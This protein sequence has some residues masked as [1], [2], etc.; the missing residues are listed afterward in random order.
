MAKVESLIDK[1]KTMSECPN[2][3]PEYNNNINSRLTGS[4]KFKELST[5]LSDHIEKCQKS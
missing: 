5:I 3:K 4:N 2:C 1:I